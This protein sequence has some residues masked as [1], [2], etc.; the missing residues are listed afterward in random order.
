MG[1]PV[2]FWQSASRCL[3]DDFGGEVMRDE[4]PPVEPSSQGLAQVVERN[5][6]ALLLRRQE[7]EGSRTWQERT[8]DR[9]TRF[10]GSMIFV[11][12]H[13]L[14]FGGLIAINLGWMP[15]VPRFDPSFVI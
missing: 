5:I 2:L 7:D 9:I 8:A 13:L 6:R 10:T 1:A 4:S 12:I 14:L 3:L 11:Y 15:L